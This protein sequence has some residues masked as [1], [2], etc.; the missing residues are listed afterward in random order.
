MYV[1]AQPF[2]GPAAECMPLDPHC[3]ICHDSVCRGCSFPFEIDQAAK[4]GALHPPQAFEH[5]LSNNSWVILACAGMEAACG[6]VHAVCQQGSTLSDDASTCVDNTA[7]LLGQKIYNNPVVQK[8]SNQ[9]QVRQACG[10]LFQL[11]ETHL[12]TC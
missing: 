7:V 9:T 12:Q 1:G 5:F 4:C 3:A 8:A 2:S 10:V 6:V 11:M